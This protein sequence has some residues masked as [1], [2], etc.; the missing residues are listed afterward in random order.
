MRINDSERQERDRKI[1]E[2]LDA[3]KGVSAICRELHVG[4]MTVYQIIEKH[5]RP[6]TMKKRRRAAEPVLEPEPKMTVGTVMDFRERVCPGDVF[7]IR[8]DMPGQGKSGREIFIRTVTVI[9]KYPHFAQ[10]DGGAVRW[11]DLFQGVA[12]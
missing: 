7:K 2:L 6:A 8:S 3:G 4:T 5:G 11:S 9:G 12:V 1:A 10:T